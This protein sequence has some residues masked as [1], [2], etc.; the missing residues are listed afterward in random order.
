MRQ[1]RTIRLVKQDMPLRH[2]VILAKQPWQHDEA[3]VGHG[4]ELDVEEWQEHAKITE[5]VLQKYFEEAGPSSPP[6]IID[7]LEVMETLG[8]PAGRVIGEL[9]EALREAQAAGDIKE[10]AQAINYLKNLYREKYG[11]F[12]N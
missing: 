3:A 11:E 6:K 9:L 1:H 7:G 5:Y 4:P 2:V 10:K 12:P 8:L